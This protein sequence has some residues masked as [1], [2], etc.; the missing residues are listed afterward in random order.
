M[1]LKDEISMK[2]DIMLLILMSL[3]LNYLVLRTWME[4]VL[5]AVMV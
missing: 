4:Q 1:K 2:E 5:W 3:I